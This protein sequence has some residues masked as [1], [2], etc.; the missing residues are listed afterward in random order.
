MGSALRVN[1]FMTRWTERD[2]ILFVIASAQG[3]E[4]DM[5]N[6]ECFP[7]RAYWSAEPIQS[8]QTAT[9]SCEIQESFTRCLGDCHRILSFG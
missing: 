3:L 8:V 2:K 9:P 4:N 5:V 1:E 6:I 7:P